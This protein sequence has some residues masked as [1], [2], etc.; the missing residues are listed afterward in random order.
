MK[1]LRQATD[2]SGKRGMAAGW[3]EERA[4]SA[5]MQAGARPALYVQDE[6]E[7]RED[8]GERGRDLH[9]PKRRG[10]RGADQTH[11]GD[12]DVRRCGELGPDGRGL[13]GEARQV[14]VEPDIEAQIPPVRA[15]VARVAPAVDG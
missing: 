15:P 2:S 8:E 12:W 13:A 7:L 6:G 9:E 11:V 14:E 10:R 1:R 5:F 3:M 4:P